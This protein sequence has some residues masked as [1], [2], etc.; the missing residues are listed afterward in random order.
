MTIAETGIFENYPPATFR[1]DGGDQIAF[2]LEGEVRRK[3][4]NRIVEHKRPYR[5][6][7]KLDSTGRE[8]YEFSFTAYFNN[9]VVE[10][11]VDN[12]RAPYPFI[13]RDLEDAIDNQATG[14]LVLPQYGVIRGKWK[15][16]DRVESVQERDVGRL[17]CVWLEDNEDSASSLAFRPPSVRATVVSQAEQT[18]FSG[19]SSGALDTDLVSLGEFAQ[20]VED[21]ML[22]PGR[23][24]SDLQSKVTANLRS[25][26][27]IVSAQQTLAASVGL[28]HDE[29]RGSEF[30]RNLARMQD[31]QAQAA[32]EKFASRPRIKAYV[33]D[34][35][36]T[37]VFEIAAR[38]KQDAAE[39]LDLNSERLEDPL[40]LER[41]D[42]IRVF[43][44]APA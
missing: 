7:A 35:E 27:R 11:G 37:S 15:T 21:L 38:L 18:R 24:V 36:R 23:K 41:G 34:V 26:N 30:W 39:L 8:A 42:V 20:Q 22:A 31:L 25:I 29:P 14:T 1:A 19:N 5:K 17:S 16:S 3:K 9:T 44:T 6:G 40:F 12:A 43:E 32:S 13:L 2:V 4:V 10:P 28:E 33:V